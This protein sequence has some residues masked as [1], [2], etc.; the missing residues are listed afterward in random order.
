MK[1]IGYLFISV[2]FAACTLNSR[3][4]EHLNR[5]MGRYLDATNKNLLLEIIGMTQPDVVKYYKSLGDSALVCHFDKNKNLS[6][7]YLRDVYYKD[8]KSENKAIQRMYTAKEV[9][10]SGTQD[11]KIYTLSTDGGNNWFFLRDEEYHDDRIPNFKRLF[12]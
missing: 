2:L 5:Q 9:T 8:T 12:P 10:E 6:R 3:Q 7:G 4:E 1:K 11:T